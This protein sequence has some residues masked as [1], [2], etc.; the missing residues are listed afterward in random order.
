LR[1]AGVLHLSLG[2]LLLARIERQQEVVRVP[3]H[4]RAAEVAEQ[5]EALGRLWPCLGVVSEAD[6]VVDVPRAQIREH[7]A[8]RDGV[9]VDVGEEGEASDCAPETRVGRFG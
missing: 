5:L 2:E 4:C 3:H 8:E 6:D 1:P 9:P 7:R